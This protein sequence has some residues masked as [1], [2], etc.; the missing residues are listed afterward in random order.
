M[1]YEIEN[2]TST[3]VEPIS[4]SYVKQW[5]K[6]EDISEDDNI[7]TEL[8]RSKREYVERYLNRILV[9]R[10]VNI[11]FKDLKSV[12]NFP[13]IPILRLE[14]LSYT[15][16]NRQT[17]DLDDPAVD[18][19]QSQS[20]VVIDPS[21]VVDRLAG[22]DIVLGCEAGYRN[23]NDIPKPILDAILLLV[24]DAYYVRCNKQSKAGY[25]S[26]AMDLLDGY[27]HRT[28]F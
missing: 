9:W 23:I 4:L 16:V 13:V 12:Y 11:Y 7:I 24:G 1:R 14:T 8:I 3:Y 20:C 19:R 28:F 6:M 27:R 10:S 22:T 21:I 25:T 2:G 15:D 26:A 18:L 17:I 5:L